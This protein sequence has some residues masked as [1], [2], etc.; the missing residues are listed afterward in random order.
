MMICAN[1]SSFSSINAGRSSEA[2]KLTES[3]TLA[4]KVM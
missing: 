4:S 1:L 3:K 2:K